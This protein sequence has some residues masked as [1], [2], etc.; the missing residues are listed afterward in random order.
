M[1]PDEYRKKHKSCYTCKYYNRNIVF[2]N[3]S[4]CE[5]RNADVF[6]VEAKKCECYT[7]IPFKENTKKE[8]ENEL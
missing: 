2:K 1:T 6:S 4:K 3:F 7:P 8:E 5:V